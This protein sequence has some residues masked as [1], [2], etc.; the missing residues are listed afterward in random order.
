MCEECRVDSERGDVETA[1]C[2]SRRDM[3]AHATRPVP[4]PACCQDLRD[5]ILGPR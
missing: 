3:G 1:S 4:V 2:F 5:R